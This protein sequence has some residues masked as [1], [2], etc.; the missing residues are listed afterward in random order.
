M[1][2]LSILLFLLTPIAFASAPEARKPSSAGDVHVMQMDEDFPIDSLKG[3]GVTT[4]SIADINSQSEAL[5]V[6]VQKRFFHQ[7]GLTATVAD[8]S[9]FD[10]DRFSLRCEHQDAQEVADRYDGKIPLKKIQKF[11]SLV[12]EYRA[13]RAR[14]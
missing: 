5:P 8:W 10:Q 14:R 12:L 2:T 4:H 9:G 1:K 7:A 3:E 11:R 13:E 6:S